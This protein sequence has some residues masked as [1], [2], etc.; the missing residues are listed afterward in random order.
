MLDYKACSLKIDVVVQT[1]ML[2]IRSVYYVSDKTFQVAFNNSHKYQTPYLG[3]R[4]KD[5]SATVSSEF[6]AGAGAR[7]VGPILNQKQG[8]SVLF[9]IAI[10][11]NLPSGVRLWCSQE[12]RPLVHLQAGQTEQQ[13]AQHHHHHSAHGRHRCLTYAF[14]QTC[15]WRL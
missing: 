2:E 6:A 14:I 7:E 9:T 4:P 3:L 12:L 8:Q 10:S 5:A 11:V 15:R 1:R 13:A